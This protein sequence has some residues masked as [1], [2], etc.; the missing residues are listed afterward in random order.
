M[1]AS[2]TYDRQ[3]SHGP[4][5]CSPQPETRNAAAVQCERRP[6][7][8]HRANPAV[9]HASTAVGTKLP[10]TLDDPEPHL[11]VTGLCRDLP[12]QGPH[13][14][15]RVTSSVQSSALSPAQ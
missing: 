3:H 2:P 8:L 6:A 13:C 1:C 10:H 15:Y 7:F 9:I 5:N 4:T 12:R 14:E 11:G